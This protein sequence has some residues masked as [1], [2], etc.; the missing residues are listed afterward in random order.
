VTS[1]LRSPALRV[2]GLSVVA[3]CAPVLAGAQL[4][5]D[6][7]GVRIVENGPLATQRA[8][9][10]QDAAVQMGMA[11]HALGET[12]SHEF[13]DPSA[14]V[15][16]SGG[17]IAVAD[18]GTAEI[19]LFDEDGAPSAVFGGRGMG[20]REFQDLSW[21][22]ECRTGFLDA[23]DA[24]LG[25]VS[26]IVIDDL[27]LASTTDLRSVARGTPPSALRCVEGGWVA[28]VKHF[29]MPTASS[30]VIR[31]PTTL[32]FHGEA[33]D[34]RVLLEVAGDEQYFNEGEL[35]PLALGRRTVVATS[36]NLIALGS[37]DAPWVALHS[38][39]GE[40]V[41][42]IGW[43]DVDRRIPREDLAHYTELWAST[44]RSES[45]AQH[46]RALARDYPFPELYPAFG[47]ILFDHSGELWVESVPRVGRTRNTWIAFGSDGGM[48]GAVAFPRDYRPM[49]IDLSGRRV[50]GVWRD[51]LGVQSVRVFPLGVG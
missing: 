14:V 22:G 47:E 30:G 51:G 15:L 37:Q 13:V 41:Q 23:Y 48:R 4:V 25:R 12:G 40:L 29:G 10:V 49:A 24:R 7:S 43:M 34:P 32:E 45:A 19:H 27:S 39:A 20:P 21:I 36:G 26:T 3:N 1:M 44:A 18:R 28:T 8:W 38:L 9:V 5:R 46:V 11:D 35:G 31:W 42:S 33:S 6:S 16:L 17:G 2:F 50:A